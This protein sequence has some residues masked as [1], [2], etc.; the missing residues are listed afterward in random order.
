[1]HTMGDGGSLMSTEALQAAAVVLGLLVL[2]FFAFASAYYFRNRRI[3]L[4]SRERLSDP[5]HTPDGS[6]PPQEG[7][8]HDRSEPEPEPRTKETS[9]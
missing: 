7:R 3:A 6:S 9:R 1:M 8:V 4:A 2:G 5:T